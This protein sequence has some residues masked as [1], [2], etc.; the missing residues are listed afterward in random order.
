MAKQPLHVQDRVRFVP[1]G[2][3]YYDTILAFFC[4]IV[5]LSN[6]VAA[7]PLQ[8]GDDLISAGQFSCGRSFLT[9]ARFF[10]HSR[11]SWVTC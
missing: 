7:K 3:G 11:T 9:V 5:V 1:R 6:I 4:V 10:F 2:T 8:V